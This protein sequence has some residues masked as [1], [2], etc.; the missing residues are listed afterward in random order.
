M[1]EENRIPDLATFLDRLATLIPST[2]LQEAVNGDA[3]Y[4]L[5][6]A[7]SM[8]KDAE[9]YF[10]MNEGKFSP[11]LRVRLSSIVEGVL[12]LLE[13]LITAFGL[14]E[15]FRPAESEM[16]ATFKSQKIMMLIGIFSTLTTT[17]VNIAGAA[18][19]GQVMG[20]ILLTLMA[21][22]IIWPL[23]KPRTTYLP[24]N[25]ANWTREVKR[26]NFVAQGR[27][28]SLDKIADI[29]KMRRHAI[30]VGP[31]R[32]GK[33][34]TAK[35]FAEAVERGDYPE[36]KGKT[37][38]RINTTDLTGK[39]ASFMETGNILNKISET[40]GRHRNDII[41]VL[42]EVHMA[43]KDNEKLAE[44]LKT[45]LDE[46]GEF[47]HVI[48]ITT[49]DEYRDHVQ[50]NNAFS[51]RFDK[52]DIENT[53]MD[54]TIKI[55]GDTALRSLSKPILDDD[56]IDDIYRESGGDKAPAQPAASLK[57]L[58]RCI[59]KTQKSQLS[60]TEKK[61]LRI[62]NRIESL[63]SRAAASR[64]RKKM[65]EIETK[66]GKKEV[67]LRD[68]IAR[69][70]NKLEGINKNLL[71]DKQ[72]LEKLY[73]S[74]DLLDLVTKE[75]YSSVKKISKMV[76]GALNQKDKKEVNRFILLHEFLDRALVAHL[77]K[78]SKEGG[79]K[80]VIDKALIKETAQEI[81]KEEPVKEPAKEEPVKE[82]VQEK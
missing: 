1:L 19:A 10:K 45:F 73:K 40:M 43:S 75:K 3:K 22:S 77:E 25:A 34:L 14:G 30:L 65:V 49:N 66:N 27:K 69:L 26:A 35:A 32:V 62:Y 54:E 72:K 4:A 11:T 60:E 80:V 74:K 53:S 70:E 78:E 17:I 33:S 59:N 47:V 52:V 48:G 13:S 63:Y 6:E 2:T 55:L 51:L 50:H 82:I 7:K 41:L 79:V 42:D 5:K 57:L 31:S 64:S 16:Q 9:H 81:A 68:E 15:F 46:N 20:G 23:I 21:L 44:Q 12:S 38:F 28:G 76:Q 58:K 24:A 8:V 36:L 71:E 67:N 56:A 39:K 37:V 29:L 18:V 61:S